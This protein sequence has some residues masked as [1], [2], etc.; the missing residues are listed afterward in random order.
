MKKNLILLILLQVINLSLFSQQKTDYNQL[1]LL[2]INGDYNQVV[3]D[4]SDLIKKDSLNPELYFKLGLAYQSLMLNDKSFEAYQQAVQL[5]PDSK[6]YNLS[7][8]KIFYNIGKTKLAQP[9]FENLC[10]Q[11][12]L[13]WV[14]SY[15]L[16][17]IYM[18]KGLYADALKIYKKFYALDT[19]NT[20]YLDKVAFCN[21]R[22][23]SL[24]K[25]IELF[26]KSKLLNSKNTSTYKNLSYL[27]S[28]KN[29]IDTAIYQL[30]KGIEIDST[31]IDIYSRRGD[32][33]YSQNWH[34]RARPDY[35]RV[36]ASGD[37]SKVVLKKLGIGFAYN[38]QPT[39]AINFLLLSYQ[40][41][42]SDFE[43]TSYIGQSYYK[44][45]QYKKSIKYYNRVLKLLS[46][47][48]RQIDYTNILLADSYKDSGQYNE[49]IN[50]YSKSIDFKYS[51]RMCLVIANI[52]D[53][54]LKN[55]EKAISY[56]QLFFNNLQK[57]EFVLGDEY[58][59]NVKK[60]LDWLIENR[61]KKKIKKP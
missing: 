23:D 2:L 28:R 48:S 47:I 59:A 40:K 56:Y 14:Y 9:I 53:E 31:D 33:Y 8:A 16:S 32:I 4:C 6:K 35:F 36:L 22:M 3:S 41:D 11:D 18:Q 26:E 54:K 61:N 55:Y 37:S 13:N 45:K 27:Y 50:Y 46:T 29:M 30:N 12:T 60:R 49:A 10:K 39:D 58:V 17:D 42:S 20:L 57:N 25:S 15:F 21:L 51:A 1:D 43:T 52:Y 5:A 24:D 7:L 34:F 19:L 38:S 44:L